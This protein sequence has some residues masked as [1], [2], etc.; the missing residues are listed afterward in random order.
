MR[1]FDTSLQKL[2]KLLFTFFLEEGV[3]SQDEKEALL[4]MA[5]DK[6]TM[7][8]TLAKSVEAG[9]EGIERMKREAK[10]N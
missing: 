1:Q 9:K 7:E 10:A 6:I 2:G 5:A 3:E 8:Y 4:K